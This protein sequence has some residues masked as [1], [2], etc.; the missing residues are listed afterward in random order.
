VNDRTVVWIYNKKGNVGKSKLCK[1]LAWKG[2]A[3]LITGGSASQLKSAIFTAGPKR[4]YLVDLPRTRGKDERME[5]ILS[6]VEALKNGFVQ[7][8]MYG[9]DNELFMMPPHVI[10]FSN[11]PPPYLK[12]SLDRWTTFTI[13]EDMDLEEW[14]PPPPVA[15]GA[16]QPG[17][18]APGANP[19]AR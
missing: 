13:T 1:F 6:A 12:L 5:D 17:F 9:K 11:A 8:H 4:C 3:K 19:F 10:C 7:D 18:Q 14:L 15:E 16:A 2:L